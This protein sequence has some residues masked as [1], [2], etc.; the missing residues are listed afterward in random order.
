[1]AGGIA[2]AIPEQPDALVLG[3]IPMSVVTMVCFF[4]Y[5]TSA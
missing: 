5:S 1:M 2:L 4:S 3:Q